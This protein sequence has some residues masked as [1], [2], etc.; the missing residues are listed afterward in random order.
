MV[1]YLGPTISAEPLQYLS[2]TEYIFMYQRRE[3]KENGNGELLERHIHSWGGERSGALAG[4]ALRRG[5]Q[6]AAYLT[7]PTVIHRE[8]VTKETPRLL[9]YFRDGIR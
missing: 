8:A 6:L 1:V 3:I 5:I 4:L 7:A 9:S 2:V